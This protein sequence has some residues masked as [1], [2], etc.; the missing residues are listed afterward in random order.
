MQCEV[1]HS[2]ESD[3]YGTVSPYLIRFWMVTPVPIYNETDGTY[4]KRHMIELCIS[5]YFCN[6]KLCISIVY[7]FFN[8]GEFVSML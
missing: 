1:Y 7:T 5:I 2:L 4:Y 3:D 6:W 8:R